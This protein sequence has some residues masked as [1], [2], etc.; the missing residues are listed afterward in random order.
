MPEV[1]ARRPEWGDDDPVAWELALRGDLA[2]LRERASRLQADGDIVGHPSYG[3]FR[4]AAFAFAVEGAES[5]AVS[6]LGAPGI[7]SLPF[8]VLLALDLARVRFLTGHPE[9]A[10]LTLELGLRGRGQLPGEARRLVAGC[11]AEAPWLWSPAVRLICATG[12]ADERLVGLATLVA[13]RFLRRRSRYGRR[14][15]GTPPSA[16]LE[17]GDPERGAAESARAG[18]RAPPPQ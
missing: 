3:A 7:S 2:G 8:P 1:W 14:I 10:F 11:V 6:T 12:G 4:A 17:E 18:V 16:G 13:A 15:A 5:E 9:H